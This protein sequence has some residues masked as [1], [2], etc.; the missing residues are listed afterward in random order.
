MVMVNGFVEGFGATGT[1]DREFVMHEATSKRVLSDGSG[2]TRR[3]WRR[4][5]LLG[6]DDVTSYSSKPTSTSTTVI[7]QSQKTHTTGLDLQRSHRLGESTPQR[8]PRSASGL[9]D[10]L[11][12][13]YLIV[14]GRK[15]VGRSND[16][17]AHI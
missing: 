1:D 16:R 8:L 7:D 13:I 14:S 5:C 15:I 9:L 12:A 10:A 2:M 11:H 4:R 17:S 3:C 6:H